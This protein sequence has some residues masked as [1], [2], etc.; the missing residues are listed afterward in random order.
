MTLKRRRFAGAILLA[1]LTLAL[2]GRTASFDFINYDDIDYVY[3]NPAVTGGVTL[4][5][6]RYAF[7]DLTSGNWHPLTWLSHMLD[8]QLF[9]LR[10]GGHHLVN[11]MIHAIAAAG[12]FL[13]LEAAT[14]AVAP[15][16]FAVAV[17]AVHPLRVQS[18]AWVSERKDVLTALFWVACLLL[19]LDYVRRPRPAAMAA[20]S[21]AFA[22][23]LM[24]KPMLVT[25]PVILLLLDAWP[26]G[27]PG[28]VPARRL[29]TEK[30]PL[31]L[32]AAASSVVAWI[33]QQE[34]EAL[35]SLQG[36]PLA[37]RAANALTS[38]VG[39]IGRTL[40]PAGLAIFYPLAR[41][42]IPPWRWGAAATIIV[43][44]TVTAVWQWRRR[45]YL[46]AGWLWY[47]IALLPVIGLVQVGDQAMADRYTY[48]P[49]VGLLLMAAWGAAEA[50]RRNAAAT[51]AAIAAGLAVVALLSLATFRE[52]SH[53]RGTIPLMERA[54]A[55][56]RDNYVAEN[57][58]GSALF[59]SGRTEEAIPHFLEAIRLRPG[60]A[61]A[62]YNL[63]VALLGLSR[64]A[65]AA[66]HF[67]IALHVTPNDTDTMLN[68]G[69][70]YLNQGLNADAA[71]LF[72]RTLALKP[73]YRMAEE[74][75]ATARRRLGSG[76]MPTQPRSMHAG[77]DGDVAGSQ[78][79]TGMALLE[80]GEAA[81]AIPHFE[82]A[83]ELAPGHP[84][85]LRGLA[86]ARDIVALQ[87][88]RKGR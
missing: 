4:E 1:V 65:E 59:D 88:R 61:N 45:P 10:P 47:V 40:W 71:G 17:F 78:V 25:L 80:Q 18:V 2:F 19:Y 41:A 58:L 84:D 79:R 29:L 28:S 64:W 37:H 57:N 55:V 49:T 6:L 75:L 46:A 87:G 42:P 54:L 69:A 14:G 9:G 73:G 32:L 13:F 33:A 11:V 8:A 36:L 81:R 3:E 72:E 63:G 31:G 12:L 85:A 86:A 51:R 70:A 67:R 44:I 24:A 27:R 68:L 82:A 7:T 76:A 48:L 20:L 39:Y 15:A 23:G 26:L 53:W 77:G 83:L 30:I 43:T 74:N 38:V 16:I 34:G 5:G 60:H 62:H 35:R 22:L 21:A 56:T 52:L 66:D 50:A